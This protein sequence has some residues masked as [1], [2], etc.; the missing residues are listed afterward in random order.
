MELNKFKSGIEE[1]TPKE[2]CALEVNAIRERIQ[3]LKQM[4][5][6]LFD[7]ESA[8]AEDKIGVFALEEQFL[9]DYNKE[10]NQ[11]VTILTEPKKIK[12][13]YEE[14]FAKTY[15]ELASLM[16]YIHF[17]SPLKAKTSEEIALNIKTRL[18]ELR[19]LERRL[20]RYN[21]LLQT[22]EN[23]EVSSSRKTFSDRVAG[24][25]SEAA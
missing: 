10:L 6:E 12:G 17:N 7:S 13:R 22:E 16:A 4:R 18:A 23:N 19:R 14:Q 21:Q 20:R 25:V 9:N 11:I 5:R 3:T 15:D 1:V 24:T 2:A 8:F